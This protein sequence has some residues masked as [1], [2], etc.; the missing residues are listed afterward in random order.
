MKVPVILFFVTQ[1]KKNLNG[2]KSRFF[3]HEDIK[4]NEDCIISFQQF[5]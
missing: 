2:R 4:V 3:Q 5:L 1:I